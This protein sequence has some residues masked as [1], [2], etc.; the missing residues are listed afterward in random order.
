MMIYVLFNQK[1]I[2]SLI[3]SNILY[4]SGRYNGSKTRGNG[5]SNPQTLLTGASK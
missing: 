5:V 3:A 1:F 2:V 4:L